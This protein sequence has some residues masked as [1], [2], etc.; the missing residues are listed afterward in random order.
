MSP[1]KTIPKEL[2]QK[3]SMNGKVQIEYKFRDDGS[4]ETQKMINKNIHLK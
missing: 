3:Y 2:Y 1:S 4:G